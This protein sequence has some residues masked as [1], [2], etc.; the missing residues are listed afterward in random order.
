[1]RFII[2]EKECRK[3]GILETRTDSIWSLLFVCLAASG[4]AL[5]KAKA[6]TSAAAKQQQYYP[7]ASEA[8]AFASVSAKSESAVTSAAAAK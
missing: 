6:V 4:P 2:T 3:S 1:M 8:S 5:A 7:N